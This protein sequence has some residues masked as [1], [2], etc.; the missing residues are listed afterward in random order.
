M[1]RA[2]P[3]WRL[4]P[5]R[6]WSPRRLPTS[7]RS[8]SSRKKNRSSSARSGGPVNRPYAAAWSSL[9]NSIATERSVSLQS[10]P[11]TSKALA[12]DPAA[13]FLGPQVGLGGLAEGDVT[14]G[15]GEAGDRSHG[16]TLSEVTV[17]PG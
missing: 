17:I 16:R 5:S 2:V 13:I 3:S 7:A 11:V 14:G 9:R 8:A 6:L 1:K 12:E 10:H 4:K 15:R